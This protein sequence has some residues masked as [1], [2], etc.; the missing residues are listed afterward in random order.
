[1]LAYLFATSAAVG[2]TLSPAVD[3][4][5]S[6]PLAGTDIGGGIHV[7]PAQSVTTT[8]FVPLQHPGGGS[9]AYISDAN[10]TAAV[11]P[12]AIA[13]GLSAP[14]TLDATWFPSGITG[15]TGATV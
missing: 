15:A 13:W 1:M 9:W 3:A 12:N 10:V 11:G 4:H 7:P 14:V 6:Y 8:Y 5:M 2:Q